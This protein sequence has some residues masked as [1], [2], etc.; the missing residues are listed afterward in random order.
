MNKQVFTRAERA[1]FESLGT[2]A[3][4]QDFLNTLTPNRAEGYDYQSPRRVLASRTAQCFEGATLAAAA[5]QYHGWPPVLLDLRAGCGDDDH[6]VATF[7]KHG[8]FGALSYTTHSVLRYREPVYRSFHSLAMSYFHEYFMDDGTKA[9]R[10]YSEPFNIETNMDSPIPRWV[11]TDESLYPI[12]VELDESYHHK[13]LVPGQR[14]R[15]AEQI[16]VDMTK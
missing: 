4:I 8:R 11:T 13:I 7:M 16:E 10:A 9:M 3:K 1:I 14:L 15:K 2:P 6:V 5:L 12:A